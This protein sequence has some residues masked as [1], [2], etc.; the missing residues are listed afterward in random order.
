MEFPIRI[1]HYLS[2]RGSS[3]RRGADELIEK[4]LVYVNGRLAVLGQKIQKEDVVEIKQNKKV[5][6]EEY[7][8]YAFNKPAGLLTTGAPVGELDIV[9]K[10]TFPT[11]VFP[12]GRLDKDSHGLIL[13]TNDGR[14]TDRLLNPIHPHEKEYLVKVHKPYKP[15]LLD[16]LAKGIVS[17][18]LNTKPCT[19]KKKTENSFTI[20]LSEGQKRQIRR[21]TALFGY[22]VV[23]LKRTRI[24][25]IELGTLKQNLFREIKGEELKTFLTSLGL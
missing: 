20:I 16:K 13:M 11:K 18:E 24:M 9:S 8:Y 6:K 22:D 4:G 19:V 12:L 10:I 23:D 14:V 25:N 2:E 1:N 21:M 5:K 15:Q 3:T 17:P 7:V